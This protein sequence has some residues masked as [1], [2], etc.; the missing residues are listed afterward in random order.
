MNGTAVLPIPVSFGV[1]G[2]TTLCT[3]LPHGDPPGGIYQGIAGA[4]VEDE[5]TGSLYF[6]GGGTTRLVSKAPAG[7]G[8][9]YFGMA[10]VK[11]QFGLVLALVSLGTPSISLCV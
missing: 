2:V 6:C 10:G 5:K 1:T 3:T 11:T 8:T 7:S 4:F 9:S